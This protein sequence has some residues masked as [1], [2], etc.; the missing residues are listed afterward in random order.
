[1]LPPVLDVLA[2]L[3]GR[4]LVYGCVKPS[5]VF[6]VGNQVKLAVDDIQHVSDR[7]PYVV[8]DRYAAPE[9]ASEGLSPKSDVW[10][11]GLTV[12]EVLTRNLPRASGEADAKVVAELAEPF[13]SIVAAC[14]QREPAKR[15]SVEELRAMLERPMTAK[16]APVAPVRAE[17]KPTKESL[18]TSEAVVG[19]DGGLTDG[20]RPSSGA[21]AAILPM[22]TAEAPT[23]EPN[24][25]G[26][27]D[28]SW[29]SVAGSD[30]F[31]GVSEG[32]GSR[33]MILIGALIFAVI[34]VALVL[35]LWHRSAAP[36]T[37]GVGPSTSG[38]RAAATVQQPVPAESVTPAQQHGAVLR[39]VMPEVSRAARNTIHGTVK[40]TVLADVNAAGQV[41]DAKLQSRGSS[42][43]FGKAALE[44]ARRWIF[45]APAVGGRPVASR[46]S[47][48]FE[49]KRS[50]D[51]ASAQAVAPKI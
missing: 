42:K 13:A 43:Y 27:A 49:F 37:A 28:F 24:D 40:V 22:K 48:R 46:W 16:K 8:S 41:S 10:S 21:P 50:G 3:H 31:T 5:S 39:Q 23:S 14:L 9:L 26:R 1:M 36:S 38:E 20:Q 18:V 15:A 6:A 12:F 44:A 33:R 34:V 7:R 30:S 19:K 51:K 25:A 35:G 29:H 32:S 4:D 2:F 47:L 45:T 11:L 17:E